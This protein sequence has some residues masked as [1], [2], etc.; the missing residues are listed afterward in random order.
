M[1]RTLAL[2]L[3]VAGCTSDP[4]NVSVS[5][6]FGGAPRAVQIAT[7]DAD[8]TPRWTRKRA[9]PASVKAT[10]TTASASVGSGAPPLTRTA[11]PGCSR[12]GWR[13]P[14]GIS[15]TTGSTTG[16]A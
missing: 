13:E 1:I 3:L 5:C 4:T 15:P 14:A 8:G 10:G 6:T 16:S 2:A 7:H 12:S 11:C 9:V